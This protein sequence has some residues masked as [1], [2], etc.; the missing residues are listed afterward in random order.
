MDA[1]ACPA[2]DLR[3]TGLGATENEAVGVA[4][5]AIA[6]QV[7]A[8]LSASSH[9][10]S[11]QV[12]ANGMLSFS[13]AWQQTVAQAS[14]LSNAQEAKVAW[15]KA[16]WNQVAVVA[17]MGRTEAARPFAERK[18]RIA[19]SLPVF[20]TQT[21]NASSLGTQIQSWHT[22][23]RL[24]NELRQVEAVLQGLGVPGAS[25]SALQAEYQKT[26]TVYAQ[27][28]HNLKVYFS[29]PR[30]EGTQSLFAALSATNALDWN[31]CVGKEGIVVA[32]DGL[33]VC[34]QNP[35]AG[36]YCV[37]APMLSVGTCAGEQIAQVAAPSLNASSKQSEEEAT[38]KLWVKAKSA[39]YSALVQEIRSYLP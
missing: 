25:S 32:T 17:C 15:R 39:D 7:Q 37:F 16:Q 1:E 21:Q 14:T 36:N 33:P 9:T 31:P 6:S 35:A 3:G 26:A 30:N 38:R 28:T 18:A 10:Q 4:R 22:A 27:S 2:G 8:V 24:Y 11:A 12:S 29:A 34:S 20:T 19:D 13:K 23:T 5:A